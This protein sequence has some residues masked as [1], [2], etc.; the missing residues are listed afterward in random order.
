VRLLGLIERLRGAYDTK[1]EVM[2]CMLNIQLG[3][4]NL[5]PIQ[6]IAIAE[7][8]RNIYENKPKKICH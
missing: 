8:Y 3:R 6:R 5:S 1:E 4:R 7:K 2:E